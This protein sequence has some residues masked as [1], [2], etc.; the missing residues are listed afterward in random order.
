VLLAVHKG[1]VVY[2][3]AKGKAERGFLGGVPGRGQ[4]APSSSMHPGS[5]VLS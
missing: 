3:E 1:R 4:R 2:S 5:A